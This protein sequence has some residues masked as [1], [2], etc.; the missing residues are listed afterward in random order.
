VSAFSRDPATSALTFIE[1]EAEGVNDPTD[2]GG[3]VAGIDNGPDD[4]VVSPDGAHVYVLA[5]SSMAVFDRSAATGRLSFSEAEENG[6]DD[7]T[8]PGGAVDGLSSGR[9]LAISADGGELYAGV[10]AVNHGVLTFSRDRTTG[11][12]SF[13]EIERQSANDP[14]DAGGQVSGLL[15][16]E[17]MAVAPD[18]RHLYIAAEDDDSLTMFTRE[19]D[20][21][22]PDTT[23]ASGPGE[24]STT[25]DATPSFEVIS[26]ESPATFSCR[27]D[28][29]APAPCPAA[30]AALT[31]GSHSLSATATDAEGNVD[32]TPA[33]RNFN[34][35]TL[36]PDTA[37]TAGLNG[38]SSNRSPS[39][40]FASP[41]AGASFECRLDD[42]GFSPCQSPKS[43]SS[44]DDGAH[45]FRVRAA[46][47]VG[48]ADPSP[49]LRS[50]TLDT[51]VDGA[52]VEADEKQK[53]KGKKIKV[54]IEVEAAETATAT[55]K[56][57]IEVGKKSYKL[58]EATTDLTAGAGE[59]LKLKPKKSKHKRKIAD[60]LDSDKKV[61]AKLATSFIDS[62]GN[63]V[64]RETTVKLKQ[65]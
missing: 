28:G 65:K 38:P 37:I 42:A 40:S 39:F 22:A 43:Y 10:T 13:L 24:G 2:P 1:V 16:I 6:V 57:T 64:E 62:L 58:A 34:V 29:G 36:A 9:S 4:V 19:D 15:G 20:F 25:A 27:V 60:A 14:T 48:N 63:E 17:D 47:V 35:D 41:E 30:L 44:L 49:A 51:K 32:P 26:N 21:I 3:P 46:D 31:D 5:N 11:K 7:P 50:F 54:K 56:G 12:I 8:D 45:T 55:A 52:T 59:K 18:D 53:Q 33:T 61:K 23:I